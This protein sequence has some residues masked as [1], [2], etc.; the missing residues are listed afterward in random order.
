MDN[1]G[2]TRSGAPCIAPETLIGGSRGSGGRRW[3]RMERATASLRENDMAALQSFASLTHYI[4]QLP[5]GRGEPCD[6]DC[7]FSAQPFPRFQ[8]L[9][10]WLHTVHGDRMRPNDLGCTGIRPVVGTQTKGPP[11]SER[12]LS[13]SARRVRLPRRQHLSD[14]EMMLRRWRQRPRG[15]SSPRDRPKDD[16][17]LLWTLSGLDKPVCQRTGTCG[18]AT[19]FFFASSSLL[20]LQ[21]FPQFRQELCTIR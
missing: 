2:T 4:H 5:A 16:P 9:S 3:E 1:A 7:K 8:F 18:T 21:R 19:C 10:E 6:I 15:R 20:R 14:D 11:L 13:R 12:P 17:P